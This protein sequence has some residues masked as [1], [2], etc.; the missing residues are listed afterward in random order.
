M[1]MLVQACGCRRFRVQ[2]RAPLTTVMMCLYSSACHTG[3]PWSYFHSTV[4]DRMQASSATHA[5]TAF[6][7]PLKTL[8]QGT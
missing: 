4:N 5:S 7:P 2:Q 8:I 6:K 1:Q 3:W